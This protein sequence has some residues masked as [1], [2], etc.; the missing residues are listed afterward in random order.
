MEVIYGY[1]VMRL[2]GYEVMKFWRIFFV[3]III[4]CASKVYA[5]SVIHYVSNSG[6]AVAPPSRAFLDA[7]DNVLTVESNTYAD[8]MGTLTL[9]GNVV[10][11]ANGALYGMDLQ[12]VSIPSTVTSVGKN[13]FN[14]CT[15]LKAVLFES[16]TVP[17]AT[18]DDSYAFSSTNMT[19]YAPLESWITYNTTFI[20]MTAVTRVCSW[21]DITLNTSGMGT[22]GDTEKKWL[23]YSSY[24]T[25]PGLTAYRCSGFT[26]TTITFEQT[27][28]SLSGK[29][30][31]LVGSPGVTY[32][33]LETKSDLTEVDNY[34]TAANGA[35]IDDATG[36]Y[37]LTNG[38]EGIGFYPLKAGTAVAAGK[39]Y[40]DLGTSSSAKYL[41]L[42]FDD[43]S[44]SIE[45]TNDQK[46]TSQNQQPKT[47]NQ[48]PTIYNL[49]GQRVGDS[50]QMDKSGALRGIVIINGKK[51][52]AK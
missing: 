50:R 7:D 6:N 23:Y 10:K 22:F 14:S 42:N 40:L 49:V 31:V 30:V 36:K 8:G 26:E 24:N 32:R 48:Q 11:F 13:A 51:Y 41:S 44:T 18:D 52:L 28:S 5:Q 46:P 19:I 20:S 47:N 45:S 16:A 12:F 25:N 15:N 17:T 35:V 34:L 9:S 4:N 33:L 3:L 21:K 38:S 43:T 2:Y 29:G 39:A 37:I 1:M 27:Y